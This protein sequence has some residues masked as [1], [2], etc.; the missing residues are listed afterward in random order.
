MQM[1]HSA[2]SVAPAM[3]ENRHDRRAAD[4]AKRLGRAVL[5]GANNTRLMLLS[6]LS[7]FLF[8]LLLFGQGLVAHASSLTLDVDMTSFFAAINQFIPVGFNI[9]AIPIGIVV[10]FLLV[11]FVGNALVRAFSGREL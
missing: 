1:T 11:R 10:A 8:A 5:R 6:A 9:Y 2:T 7:A 3:R 4:A